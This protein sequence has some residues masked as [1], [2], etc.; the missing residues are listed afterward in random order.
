VALLQRGDQVRVLDN[1]STG[2][3]SNLASVDGEFEL[4]EGDLRYERV[5]AAVRGCEAVLS[6]V[7]ILRTLVS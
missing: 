3:R 6:R 2:F 4:L 1:F 5:H 7:K